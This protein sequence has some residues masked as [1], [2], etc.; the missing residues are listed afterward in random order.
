[1][2]NHW[3][4]E[5]PEF[6][7]LEIRL[8]P[9]ESTRLAMLLGGEAHIVDLPRELQKEAISRGMKLIS[10]SQPVDWISVYLGGQYYL[11]GDEKFDPKR[12]VDQ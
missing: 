5:R 7:E 6:K 8:V 2:D 3:R 4:G 9:E 11:P 12:A 10:S 1:M